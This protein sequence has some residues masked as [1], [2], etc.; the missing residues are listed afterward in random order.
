M[1]TINIDTSLALYCHVTLE[2]AVNGQM[3]SYVMTINLL[4]T[5]KLNKEVSINSNDNQPRSV[6]TP[7]F[8][9]LDNIFLHRL[10]WLKC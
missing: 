1:E 8:R 7:L 6:C 5:E 9:I 10:T 2:Y 4:K 3:C